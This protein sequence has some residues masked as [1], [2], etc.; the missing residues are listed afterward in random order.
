MLQ[1]EFFEKTAEIYPDKI[2]LD[3]NGELSS[4]REINS[5]A[6]FIANILIENKCEPNDRI[7]IVSEKNIFMYSGILGSLKAGY[8]DLT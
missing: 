3:N 1:H 5:L 4:Y 2:A 7:C 8:L 6:N